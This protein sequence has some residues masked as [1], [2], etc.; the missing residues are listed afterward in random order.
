MHAYAFQASNEPSG[1]QRRF[2]RIFLL[3]KPAMSRQASKEPHRLC[4]VDHQS[5]V[6]G[7]GLLRA[8]LRSHRCPEATDFANGLSYR[9]G[10][11]TYRMRLREFLRISSTRL[12]ESSS[13]RLRELQH[14]V[15][16][17]SFT[18]LSYRV[19]STTFRMWPKEFLR[20]CSTWLRE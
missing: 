16:G 7:F 14:L 20:S 1:T 10:L 12:R 9:V 2:G 15:E 6:P 11:T 8:V 17:V 19:G 4:E 18:D 13:T 3:P 5:V